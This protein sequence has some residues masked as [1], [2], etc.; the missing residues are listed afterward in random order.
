[1]ARRRSSSNDLVPTVARLLTHRRQGPW[2]VTLLLILVA[3]FVWYAGRNGDVGDFGGRDEPPPV[4]AGDDSRS[5]LVER[6]IDGDTIVLAG[7]ERVRLIGVDTPET[8]KPRTP[9]QPMGP[10][11]SA[12]THR[13]LEG[14]TVRLGFD[15][16]RRDRYGRMLAYVYLDGVLVNEALIRG[17]YG[18]ALTQYPFSNAMKRR[19][20]DAE[21][22]A[23]A[24]RRG[25]W[26]L[27]LDQQPGHR[28]AA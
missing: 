11:A 9:V 8:V 2:W 17:G 26:A 24:A 12:F 18:V 5:Y 21:A 25:I 19:F 28:K 10:E 27:P 4:D 16:E 1:M 15:K 14:K 3:A 22:E 7:G 20:R 13:L 23:K 6:V